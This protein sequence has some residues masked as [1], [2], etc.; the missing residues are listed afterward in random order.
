MIEGI[1]E[2]VGW[3]LKMGRGEE[4]KME[5]KVGRLGGGASHRDL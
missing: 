2:R 4:G 1:G 5:Q 3:M